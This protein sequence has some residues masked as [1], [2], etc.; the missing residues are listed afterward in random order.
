MNPVLNINIDKFCY[1]RLKQQPLR[2]P[3]EYMGWWWIFP[4]SKGDFIPG[5]YTI[6][7]NSEFPSLIIFQ[8]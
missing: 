8:W 3:P 6:N 4:K 1:L 5:A 2:Q 7:I